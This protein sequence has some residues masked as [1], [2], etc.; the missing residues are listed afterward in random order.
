MAAR[1]Q[2]DTFLKFPIL[3]GDIGGTNAR[4]AILKDA[5]AEP[6]FFETAE[7]E[8]FR[9][10][11][12][13]IQV[14]V[15]DQTSIQPKSAVLAIAGPIDG[16]E[17]DLTN[18]HWVIHPRRMIAELGLDEVVVIND[19]EAQALAI[20]S[21]GDGAREEIGR[22]VHREGASRAVLGP[23]TGLGV[24]GLVRARNMWIPVAGEGGHIDLGARTDRD[25]MIWPHLKT[26]EGRVSGEQILCGRGLVNLYQAICK[27]DGETPR[28]TKPAEITQATETGGDAHARE[29]IDLFSIYLGRLA[30][31]IALVFIARGGV[32]IAGGIFKRILPLIDRTRMR[33]AFEDK[34]PHSAL[35]REIPLYVITEE[36]P[37][38]AGLAAFARSPRFFGLETTGRHWKR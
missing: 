37:A 38:L 3:I 4:F 9:T 24:A 17:I 10:I 12:E 5:F 36:Q 15:L 19:F 25:R 27:A 6:K 8:T 23:G 22:G 28:F 31:D 1:R 20:S 33:E 30:G 35:M 34:A 18:C 14:H 13:A 29:A 32:Y 11:D 7:T 2:P 26:I 21:L 16:D